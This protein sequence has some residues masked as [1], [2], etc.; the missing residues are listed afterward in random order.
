MDQSTPL[1]LSLS[2]TNYVTLAIAKPV[3]VIAKPVGVI[4]IP[5]GVIAQT[6]FE[7][8]SK[9]VY[10]ECMANLVTLSQIS[11][12]SV[13]YVLYNCRVNFP[14]SMLTL[15]QRWHKVSPLARRGH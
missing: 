8:T 1:S 9:L 12:Q 4:A 10:I 15:G 2:L 13:R 6:W 14:D 11:E 5:V 7:I 3:G